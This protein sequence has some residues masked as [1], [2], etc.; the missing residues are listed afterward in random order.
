MQCL[1]IHCNYSAHCSVLQRRLCSPL[2]FWDCA[3]AT[4]QCKC[5]W[6][7]VVC[8]VASSRSS[9]TSVYQFTRKC[10]NA[11]ADEGLDTGHPGHTSLDQGKKCSFST[12]GGLSDIPGTTPVGVNS[13]LISGRPSPDCSTPF[14]PHIWGSMACARVIWV[15]QLT[16][17]GW[18]GLNQ[19]HLQEITIFSLCY[20]FVC[21]GL[22]SSISYSLRQSCGCLQIGL[23]IDT[24]NLIVIINSKSRHNM[25]RIC[26]CL[27]GSTC[28]SAEIF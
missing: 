27:A 20:I 4:L 16:F 6:Y 5:T 28:L 19:E 2:Q 10:G 18:H 15:T 17:G 11:A 12:A 7:L 23:R 9:L 13:A 25:F 21:F 26:L 3:A 1:H 14:C 22:M 8:T 24:Y